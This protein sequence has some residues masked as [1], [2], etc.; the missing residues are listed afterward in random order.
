VIQ[1][2]APLSTMQTYFRDLKS[3]TAGEG[4]YSMK[5]RSY[6]RV[7]A[8]EQQRVLSELKKVEEET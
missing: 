5:P 7:P 1:A 6:E 3:Q 2:T 4:T 8:N